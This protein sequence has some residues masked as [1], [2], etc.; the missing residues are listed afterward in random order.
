MPDLNRSSTPSVYSRRRGPIRWIS[1]VSSAS[2]CVLFCCAGSCFIANLIFSPTKIDSPEGAT[3]VRE[4]ITDWNLPPG[5]TGQSALY[6]DNAVLRFDFA[7]FAHHKGRGNLLIAQL[8]SKMPLFR[9]SLKELIEQ[10]TP[11]LKK[12]NSDQHQ[13]RTLTIRNLPGEF[14]IDQGEDRASTTKYGQITGKFRGK[15]DDALIILQ[16][17]EGQLTDKEIDDFLKSIH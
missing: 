6:A 15:V 9:V 8:T 7:K 17:E 12:I 11:E 2:S 3:E 4:R 1:I 16:Y 13:T 14:Q 10:N 5:F